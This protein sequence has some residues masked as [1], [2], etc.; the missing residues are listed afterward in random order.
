MRSMGLVMSAMLIKEILFALGVGK[1]VYK[2]E[3]EGGK[4]CELGQ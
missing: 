3:K 2:V 4:Y 1:R